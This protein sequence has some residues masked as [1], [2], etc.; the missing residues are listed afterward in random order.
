MEQVVSKIKL[1][2]LSSL[3]KYSKNARTHSKEQ[4]EAIA[5]SMKE[6]G[7]NNPILVDSTNTIVAGHGRMEAAKLIGLKKVPTIK[8]EHLTDAQRRAYIIADN[9]LALNAEWDE[10]LLSQELLDLTDMSFDL[11]LLG[12]AE[13][14]LGNIMG[15]TEFNPED[16]W[17]GMPEFNQEDKSAFFSCIIHFKDQEAID[18]FSKLTEQTMTTKTK[19]VWFPEKSVVKV[20]DKRY[21]ES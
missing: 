13:Y 1:V 5:N 15:D 12:F 17:D 9:K 10:D 6:F 20:A 7:F 3:K 16:E 21:A 19:Y 11:S 4:V 14:E 8:L 2:A 18:K